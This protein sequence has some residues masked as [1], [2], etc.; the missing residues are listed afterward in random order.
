ML[1]NPTKQA[2]SIAFVTGQRVID[3][4]H[5]AR[6][7]VELTQCL[8]RRVDGRQELEIHLLSEAEGDP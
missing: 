3:N 1:R 5:I 4:E 7:R 2:A 6:Q 8:A